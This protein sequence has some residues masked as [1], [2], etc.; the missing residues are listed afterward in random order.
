MAPRRRRKS[1]FR[2]RPPPHH[3]PPQTHPLRTP[4]SHLRLVRVHLPLQPNPR[5]K[6][7]PSRHRLLPKT[8][9]IRTNPDPPNQLPRRIPNLLLVTF[10]RTPAR[11]RPR[12]RNQPNALRRV[13]AFFSLSM[14][15]TPGHP[16]P[17]STVL[18]QQPAKWGQLRISPPLRNFGSVPFYES[19]EFERILYLFAT[20]FGCD[21]T[22]TYDSDGKPRRHPI[23]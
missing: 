3:P 20:F 19:R 15:P 4:R 5:P 14:N 18:D 17:Q 13:A 23:R 10:T 11:P 21:D 16:Q 6:I 8:R 1:V 9:I 7:D 2:N 12:P 22:E